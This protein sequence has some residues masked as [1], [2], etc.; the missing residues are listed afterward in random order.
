MFSFMR[1]FSIVPNSEVSYVN[2]YIDFLT[3]EVYRST[4]LYFEEDINDPLFLHKVGLLRAQGIYRAI[5]TNGAVLYEGLQYTNDNIERAATFTAGQMHIVVDKL[6]ASLDN[7]FYALGYGLATANNTLSGIQSGI[8]ELNVSVAQANKSIQQLGD[9]TVQGFSVLHKGIS[10]L[11]KAQNMANL[12]LQAISSMIGAG[13]SMIR[14][15]LFTLNNKLDAILTELKIPEIQRE[16]RYHIEQ[17]AKYLKMAILRND[18]DYFDDALD[19]FNKAIAIESKDY[20]S[21]Y[22]IGVLY[23]RSPY[24][25]NSDKAIKAFERYL[26]YAEAE[27]QYSN[28]ISLKSQIDEV[29]LLMAEAQYIDNH[30]QKAIECTTRCDKGNIKAKLMRVK[31]L[32]ATREINFQKEAAS[33]LHTLLKENPLLSLEILDDA[34]ILSN[35]VVISLLERLRIEAVNEAKIQYI[36][37]KLHVTGSYSLAK[38]F[39][40][41]SK[42]D[43]LI[44]SNKYLDAYEA[45][46]LIEEF[47]QERSII[48][49]TND[50]NKLCKCLLQNNVEIISN[51]KVSSFVKKLH[52]AIV[53]QSRRYYINIQQI[54][55]NSYRLVKEFNDNSKIYSLLQSDIYFDALEALDLMLRFTRGYPKI[56]SRYENNGRIIL[57]YVL[58][59]DEEILSYNHITSLLN[60]L[61]I[62][63]INKAREQFIDIQKRISGSYKLIKDFESNYSSLYSILYSTEYL[64]AQRAIQ[65]LQTFKDENNI[66]SED[67]PLSR[68]AD[69]SIQISDSQLKLFI[70][71]LHADT[72]NKAKKYFEEFLQ[73]KKIGSFSIEEFYDYHSH[74]YPLIQSNEYVN[75]CEAIER[76]RQYQKLY[77]DIYSLLTN[78]NLLL[79]ISNWE[80]K[81]EKSTAISFD[82]EKLYIKDKDIGRTDSMDRVVYFRFPINLRNIDFQLEYSIKPNVL[83]SKHGYSKCID[84]TICDKS[85]THFFNFQHKIYEL[86]G[87]FYL[88]INDCCRIFFSSINKIVNVKIKR[89]KTFRIIKQKDNI[90][91]S[92]ND[93][94]LFSIRTTIFSGRL[95]TSMNNITK[96]GFKLS[97]GLMIEVSEMNFKLI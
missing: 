54:I 69:K 88:R 33:I 25:L 56:F 77:R 41:I 40:N 26:H 47:K 95:I 10:Q 39:D 92:C 13:F 90:T 14:T 58:E 80:I 24:N 68:M 29:L 78:N 87:S 43:T 85:Y 72:L 44:Y 34:D 76:I 6:T 52:Q 91:W 21:W 35:K 70:D 16:R 23:L 9:V 27:Y 31:Y 49:D 66:N 67:K 48:L 37:T 45:I 22:N 86:D 62:G 5:E 53:N 50:Y 4:S 3:N 73:Q 18:K 82:N 89:P 71:Q 81:N 11:I 65:L 97:P 30:I 61:R 93:A 55:S 2:Q 63:A 8:S 20:F 57:D 42:L 36:S 15:C 79:K 19:E 32:S 46:C 51:D 28:S 1:S 94:T 60:E 74:I 12:S 7:G 17:G 84:L 96:I 83:W 64:D 38:E 75:A 59:G